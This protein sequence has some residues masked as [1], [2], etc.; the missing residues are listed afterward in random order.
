M[1]RIPLEEATGKQMNFIHAV[2]L[3]RGGNML[4]YRCGHGFKSHFVICWLLILDTLV[5]LARH[6]SLTL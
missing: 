4:F 5:N 6:R 2:K 1:F 3:K